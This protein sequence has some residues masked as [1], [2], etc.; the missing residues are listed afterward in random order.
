MGKGLDAIVLTIRTISRIIRW[1]VLALGRLARLAWALTLRGGRAFG[2]SSGET[3]TTTLMALGF[4]LFGLVASPFVGITIADSP[5]SSA[6]AL[7]LLGLIVG[8]LLGYSGIKKV[9]GD[10]GGKETPPGDAA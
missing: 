5:V 9:R 2:A 3:K 10:R 8:S 7:G 1:L 6:L 4:G